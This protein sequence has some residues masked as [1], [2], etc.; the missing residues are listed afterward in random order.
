M[1]TTILG[2]ASVSGELYS[3][4]P[5]TCNQTLKVIGNTTLDGNSSIGGD[6]T[7]SGNTTFT[8]TVSGIPIGGAT[9]AAID[10]KANTA[11]VDIM[12]GYKANINHPT[13]GGRVTTDNLTVSQDTTLGGDLDVSVIGKMIIA[14]RITPP[15]S[16]PLALGGSVTVEGALVV[17]TTNVLDAINNISL[18]PG[19][20]G[21]TGATGPAGPQGIQGLTGAKGDT[22]DTGAQGI[23][24]LTGAT[25]LTGPAPDTS[26]Y[27]LKAS[28]V[29]SGTVTTEELAVGTALEIGR[30]QV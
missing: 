1:E 30:A 23:Q 10:L 12:L 21:A 5:V 18:T 27:A 14:R 19:A 25:G 2:N 15:A 4:G 8:G 28:P 22:G 17:G 3:A 11:D 9:Q 7:V 13:F 20:T 29:F 6:L 24:G 26:L 16:N